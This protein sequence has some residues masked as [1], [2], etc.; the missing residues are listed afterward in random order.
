MGRRGWVA[1]LLVT[2]VVS[3]ALAGVD[4]VVNTAGW[5]NVSR[6]WIAIVQ[7]ELAP[8]FLL[9]A[10]QSAATTLAYALLGTLL[11]LVLG[12][13]AAPFLSF[14]FWEVDGAAAWPRRTLRAGL[15][16][17]ARG[18][19]VVPRGINEVVWALMFAEVFGTAPL[20]AVLAIAIPFGAVTA[21]VFADTIDEGDPRPYR[22]LRVHGAGRTASL[23]VGL[24]PIIRAHLVSYA[25]YRFECAVR[26]AAI[27]G[28]TGAGGL[29]YQIDLSFQS[30]R[31][32]EMWTMIWTLVLVAVAAETASAL[33]RRQASQRRRCGDLRVPVGP[34]TR[35][36][37]RRASGRAWPT[38]T[39]MW[40]SAA[41]LIGAASWWWIDLDPSIAWQERRVD[42]GVRLLGE[43]FPPRLGPGG[44]T[45]LGTACIETL[46]MSFLA[47]ALSVG[48]GLGLAV[49]GAR[50][51]DGDLSGS[52]HSVRGL[53]HA[54]VRATVR[55]AALLARAVP[56]PVWVFLA[57][58][59]LYPG[60]WPGVV[61]LGVYNA[62]VMARLFGESLEDL[63]PHP[64]ESL[65]ASGAS[66]PQA[67][68]YATL[69]QLGPR[70]IALSVYRW[71]VIMRETVIVGVVGA[72]GLGRLI[73]DDLVARDFAALT[74]SLL[75]LILLT[76]LASAAGARLR[77]GLQ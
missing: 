52:R 6:F 41:A 16:V 47:I 35:P 49:V 9:L 29:G 53:A 15:R 8:D 73:K 26:A 23:V 71:E 64:S 59:V 22:H 69:P 43:L 40:L 20:V 14:R 25:W 3:V 45:G 33:A 72:A 10:A 66:R 30:L 57:A 50:T 38:S 27:L 21:S 18:F 1:A 7:P 56:P 31:Y 44:W 55:L 48:L 11:S 60:I 70:L 37:L 54:A 62:G 58:L 68:L 39:V 46:A 74:T 32:G 12:L 5:P 2:V 51:A 63:D 75:A 36:Q 61:A 28:V 4:D 65:R 24:A 77:R 17:A 13:F 19:G 34:S 42:L 67:F 76:A